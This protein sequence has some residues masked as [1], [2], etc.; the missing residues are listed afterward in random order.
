MPGHEFGQAGN[1]FADGE[2]RRHADAQRTPELARTPRRVVG[3]FQL[4]QDR[5]D[6]LK[7]VGARLG[8]SQGT[9]IADEQRGAELVLKVGDDARDRGLRQAP[10]APGSGEVAGAGDARE[11]F[12]GGEAISHLQ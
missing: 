10:F 9:G 12:K 5:F 1:H 7:I 3:L 4:Q 8:Q 2:A 6:A 11:Q